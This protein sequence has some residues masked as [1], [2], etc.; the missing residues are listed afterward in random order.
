MFI[1]EKGAYMKTTE[2]KEGKAKISQ[3]LSQRELLYIF[4]YILHRRIF[5]VVTLT[6]A[7][8]QWFSNC[9][10]TSDSPGWEDALLW[11]IP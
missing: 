10:K 9:N 3:F 4:M 1:L 6:H 8:Y 2:D 7:L 11:F 5:Y